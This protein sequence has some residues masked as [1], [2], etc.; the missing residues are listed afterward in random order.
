MCHAL[1]AETLLPRSFRRAYQA[2]R[3][4]ALLCQVAAGRGVQRILAGID[5]RAGGHLPGRERQLPRVVSNREPQEEIF[6]SNQPAA[7][8]EFAQTAIK[9]IV[10]RK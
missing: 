10:I 5:H 8:V 3:A 6:M 2:P 4:S 7:L 1:G 9:I